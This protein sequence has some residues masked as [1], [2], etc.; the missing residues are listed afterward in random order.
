MPMPR[1]W[2]RWKFVWGVR[3]HTNG[4][5]ASAHPVCSSRRAV[6]WST[7]LWQRVMQYRDEQ[8][9]EHRC[10]KIAYVSLWPNNPKKKIWIIINLCTPIFIND[11][12]LSPHTLIFTVTLIFFSFQFFSA[13]PPP[14][15]IF[16]IFHGTQISTYNPMM[17]NLPQPRRA[18]H[19][20]TLHPYLR[21]PFSIISGAL[22]SLPISSCTFLH[23][24]PLHHWPPLHS[25]KQTWLRGMLPPLL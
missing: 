24:L 21:S 13:L 16:V 19:I 2:R 10:P 11:C 8:E 5:L 23:L 22:Y 20:S 17:P 18:Y 1:L 4:S 9:V 14:Y 15:L 6:S 7:L 25:T 3:L 12:I